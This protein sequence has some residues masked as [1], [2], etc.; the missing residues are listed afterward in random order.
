MTTAMSW[1]NS[2]ISPQS[3]TAVGLP[4]STLILCSR[5]RPALLNETIE[6]ILSGIEVPDEMIII[7]QSDAPDEKLA[8][9][10]TDCHCNIRYQWM[11]PLGLSQARNTGI[12][13]AQNDWLVFT[14]DDVLVAPDWLGTLLRALTA[15]G[16]RTVVTGRVL[17]HYE[18]GRQSFVPST[19]ED[20]NP[21]IFEGRVGLDVLYSNNLAFHKSAVVEIGGFDERLGPGTHF[22]SAEDNDLGYRLLENRYRV[23]YAPQAVVYHR[24]WRER[25]DFLELRR[26]YGIGRGAFY[27]KHM[28]WHDLYM[29][30]RLL[31]D[32]QNHLFQF[33]PGFQRDRLRAMG[34]MVLA[35]GMMYGAAAWLWTNLRTRA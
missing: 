28:H 13:A 22:P 15:E 30:K 34:D 4:P 11:K 12:E 27:A 17:A 32:I 35:L 26:N 14:D 33:L 23:V 3:E 16:P 1:V 20:E 24:A 21:A 6:S 9:L 29:L 19:K 8:H 31:Q 7:D 5:N 2:S 10:S 25:R 18:Q